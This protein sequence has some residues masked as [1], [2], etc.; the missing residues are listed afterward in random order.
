M[1]C[2]RQASQLE[3]DLFVIIT[4]MDSRHPAS[5]RQAPTSTHDC[6]F[7]LDVQAWFL[8]CCW[9]PA[10]AGILLLLLL[11]LQG[12]DYM[13]LSASFVS[14]L[15]ILPT[16]ASQTR[17]ALRFNQPSTVSLSYPKTWAGHGTARHGRPKPTSCSGKLK[18]TGNSNSGDADAVDA[19]TFKGWYPKQAIPTPDGLR[20]QLQCQR[21]S[22]GGVCAAMVRLLVQFEGNDLHE[23]INAFEVLSRQME[24]ELN[25][26]CDVK[27][28]LDTKGLLGVSL[29]FNLLSLPFIN[30][31][32]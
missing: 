8:C 15:Y 16:C 19:A 5:S 7:T 4:E 6:R 1:T 31:K 28:W 20:V 14:G 10:A 24:D 17:F 2:V 27:S 23:D 26:K 11:L 29:L 12:V 21:G 18:A 32:H 3:A 22:S 30:A 13:S 25:F 9:H